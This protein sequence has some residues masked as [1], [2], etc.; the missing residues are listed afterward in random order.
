MDVIE[1]RGSHQSPTAPSFGSFVVSME[2]RLRDVCIYVYSQGYNL[3]FCDSKHK[4]NIF[5]SVHG[6][7]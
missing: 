5:Y 6:Y 4:V 2:S 7:Y 3:D 1:Q